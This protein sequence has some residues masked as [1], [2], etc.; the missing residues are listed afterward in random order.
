MSTLKNKTAIVFAGSRG[1]GRA[2]SER[3]GR[4]GAAVAV[5]YSSNKTAADAVVKNITD[6]GGTA[7]SIQVEVSDDNRVGNVFEEV[8]QRYGK[9]D[10]VVNAAGA[11][12]F[13]PLAAHTVENFDKVVSVNARGA[14]N[15]LSETARRI[16][17]GGRVIHI[18]TAG[19]K[20]PMFGAGLY[21]A[22]KAFGEHLALGLSKELASRG[23]T[24][25]VVS[26]GSTDTEGLAM[27]KEQIQ[28]IIGMTPL[29]RLGQPADIADVIAFLAS[30]EARWLTSQN[31]QVNGGIL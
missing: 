27:P 4:E 26:P 7:F 29:G 17:D 13:A 20:M 31:I 5:G 22:S 28:A 1:I 9:I 2:T 12:A 3:L 16:S 11:S 10:V 24:V 18:S 25:N 23:V 6:A 14:F 15:V 21:S 19:T 30:D 8:I